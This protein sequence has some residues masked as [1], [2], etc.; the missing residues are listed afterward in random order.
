M[1]KP[2][3]W[4]AMASVGVTGFVAAVNVTATTGMERWKKRQARMDKI[5]N[6]RVEW[7]TDLAHWSPRCGSAW[8]TTA[9]RTSS[10]RPR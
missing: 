4:V 1:V 10:A 3:H 6:H 7:M 9:T 2:E 8:R 5:G